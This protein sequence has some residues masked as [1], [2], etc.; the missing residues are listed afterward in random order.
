MIYITPASFKAGK[1]TCSIPKVAKTMGQ[2]WNVRQFE[3]DFVFD[4]PALAYED[5]QADSGFIL[6]TSQ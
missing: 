4:G 3:G 6:L 5:C 1:N 2:Q